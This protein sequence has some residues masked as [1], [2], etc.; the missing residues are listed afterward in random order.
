MIRIG[1]VDWEQEYV[2]SLVRYLQKYSNGKWVVSGFTSEQDLLRDRGKKMLDI[3][4]GT[5]KEMLKQIGNGI[6][7]IQ[8]WLTPVKC[9]LE[10]I[11]DQGYV[12]YRFQSAAEIGKCIERIISDYKKNTD[13]DLTWVAMYS[14]VGRCGKTTFALE[15]TRLETFGRWIY[16]GLEDY[17]TFADSA[18]ENTSLTD[19]FL[20]YWKERR[21]E[22]VLQIIEQTAGFIATGSSLLDVKNVTIE[23][24]RWIKK[25]LTKSQYKGILFDIG[26]GVLQDLHIFQEF[27]VVIVPY[28]CEKSALTKKNGFKNLLE[29]QEM[30]EELKRFWFVNMS[31]QKETNEVKKKLLG[32][33]MS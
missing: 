7:E 14:P 25:L 3:L 32:G 19:E 22:K 10:K 17:S 33:E 27:D 6:S 24:V 11:E 1:V 26:S 20:Y 9:N 4:V 23:D 15:I 31:D 21:E 30:K 5:D 13:T 16:F 29:Q 8:L 18:Q 2:K 12:A 28:L